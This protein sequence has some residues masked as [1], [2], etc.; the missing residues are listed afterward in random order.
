[1]LCNAW[2]YSRCQMWQSVWFS[3]IQSHMIIKFLKSF[4]SVVW[5][6]ALLY[7]VN[8][9]D[10]C[11][12]AWTGFNCDTWT[13]STVGHIHDKLQR[14]IHKW[15]IIRKVSLG[16]SQVLNT[17]M[18]LYQPQ[19]TLLL[20]LNPLNSAN[21]ITKRAINVDDNYTI[22]FQNILQL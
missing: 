3:E 5:L 7:H 8:K 12:L 14:L 22:F 13:A 6:F 2:K 20:E 17:V 15:N 19:I 21:S 9:A 18:K 11:F 10:L 16:G 1:M 4:N